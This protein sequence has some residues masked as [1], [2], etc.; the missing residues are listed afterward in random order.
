[1]DFWSKLWMIG[2]EFVVGDWVGG[3]VQFMLVTAWEMER[4]GHSGLR[5]II[6]VR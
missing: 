1:M 6:L 5:A 2:I 3:K 4:V